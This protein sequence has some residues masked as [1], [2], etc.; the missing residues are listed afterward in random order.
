MLDTW[1]SVP[2]ILV[3]K[4]QVSIPSLRL[5]MGTRKLIELDA[6]RAV[7]NILT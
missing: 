5:R 3:M 2:K 4:E 6:R 1:L 7:F